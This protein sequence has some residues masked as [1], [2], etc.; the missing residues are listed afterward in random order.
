MKEEKGTSKILIII[1]IFLILILGGLIVTKIIID[2]QTKVASTGN[3]TEDK[4]NTIITT[5]EPEQEEEKVKIYS[6]QDRPIAF[7]IDNQ[8]GA[9]PQ[10]SLNEAYL[11]YEIIVEGNITRLMPVY[12][13]V[14][15]EKI[16]PVRSAR[17]YFLD[18]A[19]ENDAI[20]V[21]F[22]WSPQAETDI[23]KLKVNNING[24]NE[25]SKAFWRTKD[26]SAPHNV[27]TS[28]KDIIE[29]AKNKEYRTTSNETSI[30]N[31]KVKPIELDSNIIAT[32][33]TIPYANDYKVTYEYN[34]NTKKYIRKINGKQQ[35][36]WFTKEAVTMKNII[37][38]FAQNYTLKDAEN[39]GRQ[40]LNNIGDLEGY[41]ITNGKAIKIICSKDSRTQKTV[42]K[43]LNGNQIEVNDGNTFINI[44][45]TNMKITITPGENQSATDQEV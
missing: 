29:I 41:Y 9:R 13:G 23:K 26:K 22:G 14:D 5:I 1:L 21:H 37:I 40:G 6:G 27:L 12:K 18:Y 10:A 33:I 36:D 32:S 2:N 25:S 8:S 39:K 42:Y 43:D 16:G 19:L 31:Y 7:M 45:N 20:Y 35:N 4:K 11:V 28:T 38:T 17:H 44:C 15:I 3:E 34:E 24:I 30:L